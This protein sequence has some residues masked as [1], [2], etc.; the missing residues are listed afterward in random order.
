MISGAGSLKEVTPGMENEL[1]IKGWMGVS[2]PR[3]NYFPEYDL[4]SGGERPS[5]NIVENLEEVDILPGG[6]L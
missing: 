6:Y 3:R 1:R 4:S 2:N 5:Q